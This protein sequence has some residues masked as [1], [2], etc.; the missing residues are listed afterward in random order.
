MINFEITHD[1]EFLKHFLTRWRT[2]SLSEEMVEKLRIA[3]QKDVYAAYGYGRWLSSVNP[4]G[5]ILGK[6]EV[7]LAW[8]GSGG[9]QDANAALAEIY[10][11]GRTEADKAQPEMHA[12]LMD[13]SYKLGSELAQFMTL[14]HTIYGDYGY[15]KD[16]ATVADILRGHIEK[17]PDVDPIY[18][19]LWGQAL[20][21][22]GLEGAEQA[23]RRA[24]D[25]GET[26]SYYSLAYYYWNHGEEELSHDIAREGVRN[27]A[28]N[29]HRFMAI[30]DQEK[31]LQLSDSEQRTLHEEI[32]EGLDYA[33]GH[34][35]RYAYFLKALSLYGGELGFEQD[36]A[37]AIQLFSR[38][39]EMGLKQ[40]Y[41]TLAAIQLT[42]AE[43]VPQELR[44][45]PSQTAKV[46]LQ[47]VRQG[48]RDIL[49]LE[50]VVKG[51]VTGLLNTYEEE[52]EK[53]WLDKYLVEGTKD[54]DENN[55][56]SYGVV[57]VYPQGFYYAMD[58]EVGPLNLDS[59]AEEVDARGF[60]VVH[61]SPLLTRLTKALCFDKDSC[62]VAM[63]V[64]KDG[65]AKDLPDNMSATIIYGQTAEIRGTVLFVLESDSDYT[66]LPMK[67]VMRMYLF[68]QLLT[69]A[70]GN[71]VRMPTDDELKAIGAP[72]APEADNDNQEYADEEDNGFEEYDDPTFYD[73]EDTSDEEADMDEP[74]SH[75]DVSGEETPDGVPAKELT[76]ALDRLEEALHQCN[77]CR[78][79]LFVVLPDDERF[80]FASTNDLF[81]D[82]GIYDQIEENIEQHGGYMIDEWQ[83]VDKRQIP[84]DIRSRVR[85]T[86]EDS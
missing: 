54:A 53:L 50:N 80:A 43:N 49:Y 32:A 52:I 67:G 84:M 3:S 11:D 30:M 17:N 20:E 83:Y 55:G 36:I 26:E 40:C 74:E 14:E 70:T 68:L 8:A 45:T 35:D 18:Y 64:D 1:R 59:I 42:E 24:L 34:H 10:Y 2:L 47:A 82:L 69:A 23:Y 58:E 77:L 48:E 6:A 16:P 65:C 62:H 39:C 78:D 57:A 13:S 12:F 15:P 22:A 63:L 31:F 38:G 86:T 37:T 9:V 29:C 61:Y 7:L 25:Y 79:T 81:Y 41:S 66:L 4:G 21:E 19:D 56:D 60:D 73:S 27:G 85:F 28:V 51:Y 71:L 5:D 72:E 44:L 33:I 46:C 76:I 75:E